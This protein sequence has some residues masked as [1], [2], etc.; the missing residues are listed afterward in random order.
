MF[1]KTYDYTI[2][3]HM[4]WTQSDTD[5]VNTKVESLR[6]IESACEATLDSVRDVI[7][8]LNRI[9][10]TTPKDIDGSTM[11]DTRRGDLKTSLF[12]Q[13]DTLISDNS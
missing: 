6:T 5:A 4:P 11:D 1:V 12:T 3:T 7:R 9:N 8:S 2:T 10:E 13:A